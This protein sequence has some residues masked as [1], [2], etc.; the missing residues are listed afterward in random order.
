V[1]IPKAPTPQP[2]S[3]QS[4]DGLL[5]RIFA[6]AFGAFFGLCLL[7]FGNLPIMAK[8]EAVPTDPF[9]F[10][11]GFP[12]P[13]GWAYVLLGVLTTLGLLTLFRNWP[14]RPASPAAKPLP[15]CSW[16]RANWL[17]VVLLLWFGWVC[18]SSVRSV[19]PELTRATV[20][21]FAAAGV[22]FLLGYFVLPRSPGE[23][24]LWT[25]LLG[26][27]VLMLAEG[28][29]QR[30]GGLEETRRYFELYVRPQMAD[31]PQEFIDRMTKG[32][33]FAT[34]FYPNALAG[35]L[36]L[37]LPG[38]LATI[39][40]ARRWFTAPARGLLVA[41]VAAASLACLYWSGSKAGWLLMLVLGLLA[42]LRLPVSA[43]LRTGLVA[44]LLLL[45][46]IGFFWKHASFFEKG[47]T[48][49]SARFGYWRAAVQTIE[50]RPVLGTGPGTFYHAYQRVR[51]PG[52]EPTRLTHN[53]Y[54]EQGSDSG[55]PG[56]VLYC[57]LIVGALLCGWPGTL[58]GKRESRA[59]E[60]A[61]GL[62]FWIWLGVLGWALQSLVEF[63][64]YIPALAWPAFA[65][66][67]WLVRGKQAR[68]HKP[69]AT[70]TG[71]VT[72]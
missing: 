9:Q 39:A 33:V 17:P 19:D 32:R 63:G 41:V 54:L 72:S 66:L 22:C 52:S 46:L 49:V 65:L 60:G 14:A 67:G 57:I 48:S 61:C 68:T 42:L 16:F 58:L 26:G 10:V 64:L 36:L 50:A 15:A 31:V 51:E 24:W 3:A 62:D 71:N 6:G 7:K 53:D 35:A 1:K 5:S 21:H 69:L 40:G 45:G 4:E 34:L 43:R 28:W 56:M 70:T 47:A 59:E 12:W 44:A 38:V 30:F 29:G 11:L 2:K 37:F 8:W 55:L 20:A 25:A 27:F 13:I 23:R 18:I